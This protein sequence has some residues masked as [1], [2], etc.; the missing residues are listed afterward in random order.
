[1]LYQRRGTANTNPFRHV[2][3]SY[4]IEK[5]IE[6]LV[7]WS[8]TFFSRHLVKL[9]EDPVTDYGA[10]ISHI[11]SRHITSRVSNRALQFNMRCY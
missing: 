2:R 8:R 10:V 1:M 5:A 7:F 4:M 3:Y 9:T 11:M 6:R